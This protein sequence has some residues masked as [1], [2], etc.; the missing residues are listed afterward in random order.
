MAAQFSRRHVLKLSG[1]V[2]ASTL[3][4]PG[5]IRAQSGIL[6]RYGHSQPIE[7]S[8]HQAALAFVEAVDELSA[9]E[10]RVDLFPNN[11][12]GVDRELQGMIESG[13]LDLTHTNSATL[14]AFVPQMNVMN[15]P[16][17]WQD[18]DHYLRVVDGEFGEQINAITAPASG[19]R[20]IAWWF[21]GFRNVYT[22]SRPVESLEDMAGLKVRSP[23]SPIFVET[24]RALGANPTPL[25]FP[26]I[27]SALE[28]GVIDGFEGSNGIIWSS[29]L[30]EVSDYR[31]V[32]GHIMVGF[33]LVI[34]EQTYAG[35]PDEARAVIAEAAGRAQGVQRDIQL[36]SEDELARQ[37]VTE[38]GLTE[39]QPDLAAFRE[40]VE[41]V[42]AAFDAEAGTQELLATIRA[43]A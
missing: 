31:V 17:I 6:L 11:Q 23:Q 10:I 20:F 16:F 39:N 42:I 9:G 38:G 13:S 12:L 29:H 26:E 5:I 33:G 41:P 35:L 15:Y 22:R 7:H 28:A 2:A 4:A 36:G 30:Y 32:T 40:A 34:A 24:F 25:A 14:A 18:A 27:Y 37:F 1:G 3:A 21:D 19:H 43:G 8:T